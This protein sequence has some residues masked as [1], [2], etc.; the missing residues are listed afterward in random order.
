[1]CSLLI[2]L[3][4]LGNVGLQYT[5]N[6]SFPQAAAPFYDGL[7]LYINKDC[8]EEEVL[9]GDYNG[10]GIL[11]ILDVVQLVNNVLAGNYYAPGDINSDTAMDILDVVLLVNLILN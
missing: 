4:H 8:E 10:D 7:A 5:F 1:M 6:N 2:W 11:D 9:L 3:Y